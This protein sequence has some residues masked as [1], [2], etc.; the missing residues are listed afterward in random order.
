MS[1]FPS[2][3]VL[4]FMMTETEWYIIY[5]ACHFIFLF[6][7][8]LTRSL[9]FRILHLLSALLYLTVRKQIKHT[10]HLSFEDQLHRT[11]FFTMKITDRFNISIIAS[12]VE[13]LKMDWLFP[14]SQ[15]ATGKF[16]KH[17][18]RV[19]HTLYEVASHYFLGVQK[20]TARIHAEEI[21][22]KSI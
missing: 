21:H 14:V 10:E 19:L 8:V 7:L 16:T 22:Q 9:P 12:G 18:N 4:S 15:L 1:D 11:G 6:L 20:T 17:R 5:K 3:L 2:H 13:E